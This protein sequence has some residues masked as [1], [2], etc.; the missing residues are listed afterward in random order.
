MS[1]NGEQQSRA[2]AKWLVAG[3]GFIWLLTRAW[4]RKRRRP[5]RDPEFEPRPRPVSISS[6]RKGYETRDA[7][8]VWIFAF[9]IVLFICGL[10]IHLVLAGWLS[11]LKRSTPPTDRWH[12]SQQAARSVPSPGS[13]PRLQ[14]APPVDL[15]KFRA[16]EESE[17]SSY[18][19]IN[20]T[21]GIVKIPI[22]RAMELVLKEG[23]PTRTRTN[24]NQTGP[25][26]YQLIQQR[27]EHRER[28]FPEEK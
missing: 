10:F 26:E 25:S 13:Y 20:R 6:P 2:R 4:R 19:W 18:G 21:A 14:I 22:E 1:H 16:R 17:L 5:L 7:N 12:P 9:V 23:L 28:E 11:W 8:P 27:L 15:E 3:A 24:Q